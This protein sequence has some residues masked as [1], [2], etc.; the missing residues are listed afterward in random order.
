ML[1]KIGDRSRMA[2]T[3]PSSKRGGPGHPDGQPTASVRA[4]LLLPEAGAWRASKKRRLNVKNCPLNRH[5]PCPCHTPGLCGWDR[6]K[7][8]YLE[9]TSPHPPARTVHATHRRIRL[10]VL[11]SDSVLTL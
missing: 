1:V 6:D 10:R 11:R 9:S 3:F 8:R 2:P 7:A 4:S 5:G